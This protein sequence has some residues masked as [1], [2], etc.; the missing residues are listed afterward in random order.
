MEIPLSYTL[1]MR[2]QSGF[3]A[4]VISIIDGRK[5]ITS[6][7]AEY[8]KRYKYKQSIKIFHIIRKIAKFLSLPERI[9]GVF[10]FPRKNYIILYTKRIFKAEKKFHD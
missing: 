6:I 8:S 9:F 10:F 1:A 7:S 2:N 3:F 5:K 4:L